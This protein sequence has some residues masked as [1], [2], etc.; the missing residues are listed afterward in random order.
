MPYIGRY[1]ASPTD[2]VRE[3]IHVLISIPAPRHRAALALWFLSLVAVPSMAAENGL[4]NFPYGAQTTYAAYLPAPGK[5]S[6]YGY[7]LYVDANSVRDD[8]GD[9]IPGLS[10]EALAV[11]PRVVHTWSTQW[12]G[13]DL[14]TGGV[15]QG[16]ALKVDA[17]DDS[18]KNTG[19]TLLAIEPL[20][21]SRSF[22]KWRF[23]A[24]PLFYFPLGPYEA[25]ALDN[26][27]QNHRSIAY[28]LNST[29]TPTPNVDFSL[30]GTVEFKGKNK[31]TDYQSGDQASLTYGLGYRP[32]ADKRWDLGVSGYFTDG[33]QDD[34]IDGERVPGGGRTRKFAI[35][36]KLVFWM[37]PAAA[38]VVQ[39]HQESSV[40]NGSDNNLL[41]LECAFPI[42]D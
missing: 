31:T 8:D 11:A 16:V 40:R 19:G 1:H 12:A 23:L 36:P 4:S 18:F 41:W 34:K 37:S 35:G 20:H 10:V 30:N 2:S 27:T 32:F 21:L 9:R 24:G 42:F 26:T 6:F 28:E 14:S 22:G 25:G 39:Y 7:A 33:L 3:L 17:G 5:T 15:V 13:F 29:W 38:I